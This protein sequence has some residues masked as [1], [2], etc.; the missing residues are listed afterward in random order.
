MTFDEARAEADQELNLVR[1]P[2]GTIEY[3]PK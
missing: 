2:D 3:A 1:D